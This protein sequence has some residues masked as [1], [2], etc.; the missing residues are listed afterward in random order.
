M[1]HSEKAE[2]AEALKLEALE[3]LQSTGMSNR[4]SWIR[5]LN[6]VKCDEFTAAF[7]SKQQKLFSGNIQITDSSVSAYI[8]LLKSLKRPFKEATAVRIDIAIK[9][10][11]QGAH[12]LLYLINSFQMSIK[13]LLMTQRNYREYT[14]MFE[15]L[16]SPLKDEGDIEVDITVDE[17][18]CNIGEL[19]AVVKE[20]NLKVTRLKVH[21]LEVCD[22]N[23]EEY[24]EMLKRFPQLPPN[25]NQNIAKI[26]VV[27]D[28]IRGDE[29]LEL[30]VC[31]HFSVRELLIN[32]NNFAKYIDLLG[33]MTMPFRDKEKLEV[34]LNVDEDLRKLPAL[35]NIIKKNQFQFR[36]FR[37]RDFIIDDTNF[38]EYISAFKDMPV[39]S[40]QANKTCL[41]INITGNL[42][43]AS[44][45][46]TLINLNGFTVR[47]FLVTAQNFTAYT[48]MLEGM[49]TTFKAASNVEMHL[50]IDED[51]S[52]IGRLMTEITKKRFHINTFQV[53][54][55]EINDSNI[56]LCLLIL[57]S[58][59]PQ[60]RNDYTP[61]VKIAIK[62]GVRISDDL[63]QLISNYKINVES[64]LIT[65]SNFER[66]V[67]VLAQGLRPLQ[68]ASNI[69]IDI[70][71]KAS[72]FEI[73]ELLTLTRRHGFHLRKLSVGNG[74]MLIN[75][76]N[77]EYYILPL[78][79]LPKLDRDAYEGEVSVY[80]DKMTQS[81]DT[82]LH[83]LARNE[84]KVILDLHHDFKNPTVPTASTDALNVLFEKC[85]VQKYVGRMSGDLRLPQTLETLWASVPDTSA[86]FKLQSFLLR[87]EHWLDSLCVCASLN[88]DPEKLRP[89]QS[90]LMYPP[91]LCIPGVTSEE[92]VLKATK[93][94]LNFTP[95][96]DFQ[97]LS[98]LLFPDLNLT[99]DQ[100]V[101]CFESNMRRLRIRKSIILPTSLK[102]SQVFDS[103]IRPKPHLKSPVKIIKKVPSLSIECGIPG[104]VKPGTLPDVDS[105]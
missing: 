60:R 78:Q 56:T 24:I 74:K 54:D 58:L 68:D 37:V 42:T 98:Y 91:S 23:V 88:L 14:D 63:L 70:Q 99:Q 67:L 11:L 101:N 79:N 5:I 18:L 48:A 17:D 25:A 39:P 20:R 12:E 4:D 22:S 21:D 51:I 36:L 83:E 28:P 64:I 97:E 2:I 87:G 92:D 53:R 55:F 44:D 95:T 82:I 103:L 41:D 93:I 19:L 15:K 73:Q 33:K 30:L 49:T 65:D 43:G 72:L 61:S 10:E 45:L 52:S 104:H 31:H 75:T 77:A 47:R 6:S 80:I 89:L 7:I 85:Q 71:V 50:I 81:T 76:H 96:T 86:Y 105:W 57:R 27:G 59:S 16:S 84:F 32:G 40:N 100:E 69:N 46:L 34:V 94:A 3:L 62:D 66:Y 8:A 1:F 26:D 9:E 90:G 38:S 35:L 29:L 13:R 102:K